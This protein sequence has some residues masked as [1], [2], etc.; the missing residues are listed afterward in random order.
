M[1]ARYLKVMHPP[2]A[3][4]GAHCWHYTQEA[5]GPMAPAPRWS[6]QKEV[7]CWCGKERQ[8]PESR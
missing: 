6:D 8:K 4:G 7:C 5:H 3:G 1:D 2:C